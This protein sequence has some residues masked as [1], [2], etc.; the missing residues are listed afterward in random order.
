MTY[1]KSLLKI[2]IKLK[3]MLE[4]KKPKIVMLNNTKKPRNRLVGQSNTNLLSINVK[5]EKP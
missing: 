4:R 1:T 3:L 2:G 5:E